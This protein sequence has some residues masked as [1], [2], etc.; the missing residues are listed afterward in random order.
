M[1][2]EL[3]PVPRSPLSV[4]LLTLALLVLTA[5]C[6]GPD[7]QGAMERRM[8]QLIRGITYT[9]PRPG[10]NIDTCR[11]SPLIAGPLIRGVDGVDPGRQAESACR[12][13]QASR[14]AANAQAATQTV[15]PSAELPQRLGSAHL[16]RDPIGLWLIN[17]LSLGRGNLPRAFR[18]ERP[19]PDRAILHTEVR[20]QFDTV[21]YRRYPDGT[22]VT[23]P[24]TPPGS[25]LAFKTGLA[26]VP[27][28]TV[29]GQA[30]LLWAFLRGDRRW[31]LE[32]IRLADGSP[33]WVE[34]RRPL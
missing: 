22:L 28:R 7:S 27:P 18:M 30:V 32:S 13:Y 16:D 24:T 5:G 9:P 34:D 2:L 12:N 29:P 11:A 20:F 8:Q 21:E 6:A 17:W 10:E 1:P 3:P 26:I 31:T 4:S 33:K 15:P 25:L 19:T 14:E 23:L